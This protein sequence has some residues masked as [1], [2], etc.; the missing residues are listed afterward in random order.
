MPAVFFIILNSSLVRLVGG[1]ERFLKSWQKW[2]D[3]V[4]CWS[5]NTEWLVNMIAVNARCTVPSTATTLQ[6]MAFTQTQCKCATVIE[7]PSTSVRPTLNARFIDCIHRHSRDFYCG[8]TRRY[9]VILRFGA[10][11]GG[12]RSGE[13]AKLLP[14]N[15]GLILSEN[16]IL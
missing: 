5:A 1:H 4:T 13:R 8:C 3:V 6:I 14:R 7:V 16:G 2:P 11:G 9:A 10:L 15:S 12:V